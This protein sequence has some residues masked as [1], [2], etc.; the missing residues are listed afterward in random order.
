[1]S[2]YSNGLPVARNEDSRNPKDHT[3]SLHIAPM[4]DLL[5]RILPMTL[6]PDVDFV[7]KKYL[8]KAHT[9]LATTPLTGC[10]PNDIGLFLS[11]SLCLLDF[12]ADGLVS[13]PHM[14][15]NAA[16]AIQ[17]LEKENDLSEL[18]ALDDLVET[19]V[20]LRKICKRIHDAAKEVRL[21]WNELPLSAP[22]SAPST[23]QAPST[24][25]VTVNGN[26][27][28]V[29][30]D[31]P[32]QR[33]LQAMHTSNWTALSRSASQADIATPLPPQ[34]QLDDPINDIDQWFDSLKTR[35]TGNYTCP[36]GLKC[37]RGA[38]DDNGNLIVFT[39]N[40]EIRAHVEKHL[41]R[42]KCKLPNCPTRKGF[43]RQDQ[44]KRHQETV[45]H[46]PRV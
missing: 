24:P 26:A 21:L 20:I 32:A 3:V 27:S 8:H 14:K 10:M 9:H 45:D 40:S 36:F 38:V 31:T 13:G 17:Q 33:P 42:W 4:D 28:S 15:V 37:K 1:M 44:L 16:D 30:A 7:I 35:G 25:D 19:R 23:C 6:Q 34:S 2:V 18:E 5:P 11:Q 39:R 29:P 12:L 41:K 46:S 43:S 22:T